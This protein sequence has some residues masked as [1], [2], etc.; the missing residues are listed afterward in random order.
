M[1]KLSHTEQI[2]FARYVG[3]AAALFEHGYSEESIKL[4]LEQSMPEGIVKEAFWG[5]AGRGALRLG[6]W[7]IR[8]AKGARGARMAGKAIKP[9][10]KSFNL[11]E[12]LRRG[13]GMDLT[14][15]GAKPG[16]AAWE[17]AKGIG[18][19]MIFP[20]LVKSKSTIGKGIGT[21]LFAKSMLGGMGGGSA[22]PP[23]PSTY[24]Y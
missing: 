3:I 9:G 10:A 4:A 20:G 7:L 14:R 19:N 15:W 24:G 17:T 1:I 11:F 12:G 2:K 16:K 5:A 13:V 6:K 21:G 23:Q 8:G 18:G 22:P